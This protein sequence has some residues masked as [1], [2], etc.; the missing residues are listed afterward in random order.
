[1]RKILVD[2]CVFIN[3]FNPT[4]HTYKSSLAFLNYMLEKNRPITMPA[5]AWFEVQC[6][7]QKLSEQG[8]YIGPTFGGE[9][10]YPVELINIDEAFIKK[11]QMADIPYIKAG[12]YIFLAVAKIENI[13]IITSDKEMLKKAKIAGI[14]AYHIND[15]V[16]EIKP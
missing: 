3:S 1:M 16:D 7:L 2:S 9:M 15:L 14:E 12:D 8:G 4:S 5:H 6:S 13:P 10:K 11:Y